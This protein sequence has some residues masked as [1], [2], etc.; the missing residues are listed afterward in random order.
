MWEQQCGLTEGV[1]DGAGGPEATEGVKDKPNALLHL[2]I[3]VQHHLALR[4]VQE[5]DRKR[6]AQISASRFIEETATHARLH[7]VQFCLRHGPL[8]PKQ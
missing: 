7:H 4:I 8:Q 6:H 1:H 5:P 3:G 2:L